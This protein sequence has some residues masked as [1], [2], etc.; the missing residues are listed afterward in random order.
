MPTTNPLDSGSSQD[1]RLQPAI[2]ELSLELPLDPE[3]STPIITLTHLFLPPAT[4]SAS[5]STPTPLDASQST[6]RAD[7]QLS[8]TLSIEN[9]VAPPQPTVTSMASYQSSPS[10]I[11]SSLPIGSPAAFSNSPISSISKLDIPT[12][13]SPTATALNTAKANL[14]LG[15]QSPDKVTPAIKTVGII[16]TIC[17]LVILVGFVTRVVRRKRKLKKRNQVEKDLV[18][19]KFK[20]GG[21]TTSSFLQSNSRV[22]DR[23]RKISYPLKQSESPSYPFTPRPLPPGIPR[24]RM[25]PVTH[26]L[27]IKEVNGRR[28]IGRQESVLPKPLTRSQIPL[29]LPFTRTP[30]R[31]PTRTTSIDSSCDSLVTYPPTK[32]TESVVD[33]DHLP[34]ITGHKHLSPIPEAYIN[35]KPVLKP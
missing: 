20:A 25:I 14:A 33:L 29:D 21:I 6:F 13:T 24:E 31:L 27:N 18:T 35:I 26:T 2:P 5:M 8:M 3:P 23:T 16:F 32:R 10:T 11:S 22:D 34:P 17:G 12:T 30:S 19:M 9:S 7:S 1:S 4:S 15:N 28:G